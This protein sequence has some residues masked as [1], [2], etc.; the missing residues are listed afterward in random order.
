MADFQW[1]LQQITRGKK[2]CRDS[3]YYQ[4]SIGKAMDHQYWDLH[5]LTANDRL[6][7]AGLLATDW[8]EYIECF[9]D[10]RWATE[11]ADAGKKVRWLDW[12]STQYLVKRKN[13]TYYIEDE[14]SAYSTVLEAK[15]EYFTKSRWINY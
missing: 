2:V 11:M 3:W 7:T 6:E 1:A 12:K 15:E 9:Y 8:S 14:D 4:F 5:T 13:G 10:F